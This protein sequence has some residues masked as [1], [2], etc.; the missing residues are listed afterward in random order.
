M[1]VRYRIGRISLI[2]WLTNKI[3]IIFQQ[4]VTF[5]LLFCL[6]LLLLPFPSTTLLPLFPPVLPSPSPSP[7][8]KIRFFNFYFWFC[9]G[10]KWLPG[11]TLSFFL[12]L[13]LMKKNTRLEGNRPRIKSARN[14]Y[15]FPKAKIILFRL[16]FVANNFP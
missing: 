1:N 11:T 4:T 7:F 10:T 14:S 5:S 9:S 2:Q 15:F 16:H 6:L 13:Y 12:F 3:L 8:F